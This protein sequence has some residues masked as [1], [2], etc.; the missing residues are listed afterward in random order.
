[1]SRRTDE[2]RRRLRR[3]LKGLVRMYGAVKPLRCRRG[4]GLDTLVEAMLAQNTNMINATRGYRMLR[5]RFD[6][7][8]AV[9]AAPVG[10]VQREIA[11]CG[12]ARMRA[13]RLQALL[14]TVLEQRGSLSLDFL[15]KR[16]VEEAFDYLMSF[17]GIGPKTAAFTCLF[18]FGHPLLPVDNG[19]LRVVRRL[20]LVRAKAR[21]LEAER[22]LSPLIG[23]GDHHPTHVLT[24]RH[25]KE[26]CRV[27]NPKCGE[28]RLLS[29]CPYGRRK[30]EHRPSEVD[31]VE[32]KRRKAP[33]ALYISAGLVKHEEERKLVHR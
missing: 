13:R 23:A 30:V 24:F 20:G 33:I 4:A 21:D 8:A 26:R 18:G 1:M 17:H 10:E 9:L 29:L 32:V 22:V 14:G 5:R 6:S 3:I 7:W 15:A 12:L 2:K 25:A 31:A 16:P 28:C 27:R 19:V 11:V